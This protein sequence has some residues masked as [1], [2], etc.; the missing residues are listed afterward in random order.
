MSKPAAMIY[1]Q[2]TGCDALY[3]GLLPGQAPGGYTLPSS[4]T[5]H[6]LQAH[7][8]GLWYVRALVLLQQLTEYHLCICRL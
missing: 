6:H 5:A 1:H 4:A 3:I 2:P 7:P 8:C